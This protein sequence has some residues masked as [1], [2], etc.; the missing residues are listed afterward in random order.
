MRVRASAMIQ[1]KK[2]IHCPGSRQARA[3]VALLVVMATTEE[4]SRARFERLH[5]DVQT[6]YSRVAKEDLLI[7]RGLRAIRED[8]LYQHGSPPCTS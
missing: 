2:L 1:H 5:L 4:D 3:F 8:R 6:S 7:A